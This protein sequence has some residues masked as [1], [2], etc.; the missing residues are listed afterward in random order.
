M[1]KVTVVI[2]NYNGEK[3]LKGCL[4]S[5]LPSVQN[6]AIT[7]DIIVVDD[8]IS[9]GDSVLLFDHSAARSGISDTCIIPSSYHLNH[10]VP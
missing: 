2:P 1:N 9:S 3:Y 8:M 6:A 5:I 4:D 10:A 7:Y